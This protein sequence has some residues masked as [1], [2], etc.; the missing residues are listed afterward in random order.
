MLKKQ[1]KSLNLEKNILFLGAKPHSEV[2]KWMQKADIF[3]LPSVKAKS[4]DMEGL[5]TV[6]LEASLYSVPS[7]ATLHSGIPEA[8]EDKKTGLLVQE[9]NSDELAKALLLLLENENLR[10]K[11]GESANKMV[12]ERFDIRKQTKKLEEIY[13]RVL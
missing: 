2:L 11:M 3:S 9:R 5:P 13:Q 12:K 6:L 7:V 4:G 1:V 10:K 8:I